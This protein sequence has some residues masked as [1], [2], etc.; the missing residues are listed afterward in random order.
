MFALKERSNNAYGT[1]MFMDGVVFYFGII[2]DFVRSELG[3]STFRVLITTVVFLS[4]NWKAFLS[5][6]VI[7]KPFVKQFVHTCNLLLLLILLLI[8]IWTY[9]N[10]YYLLLLL[11]AIL[12]YMFLGLPPGNTAVCW[13]L[14]LLTSLLASALPIN[15]Q[16]DLDYYIINVVLYV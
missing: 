15:R 11:I 10:L 7:Y 16:R 14:L 6:N 8:A 5:N 3:I 2:G 12:T 13:L 1:D 4:K 9:I